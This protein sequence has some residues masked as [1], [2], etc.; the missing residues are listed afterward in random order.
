MK[1]PGSDGLHAVF[2]KKCWHF[3]GD[4]LTAEVLAAINNKT[5]PEGWNDTI[6]ILIPKVESPELITE[7][8]PTNL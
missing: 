3:I 7:Y 8:R 5:I 2:F 1:A 4:S 6:I